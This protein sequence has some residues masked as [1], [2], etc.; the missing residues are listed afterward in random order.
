MKINVMATS[1]RL[2]RG[3]TAFELTQAMQD[4]LNGGIVSPYIETLLMDSEDAINV[5]AKAGVLRELM[6][7]GMNE[8]NAVRT[9][10]KR[11]RVLS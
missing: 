4:Y 6:D 5:L 9:L 1:R 11:M 2:A 10:A 8:Q 3:H 7:A